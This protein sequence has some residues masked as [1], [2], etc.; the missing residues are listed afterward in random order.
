MKTWKT[1]KGTELFLLN[2][3]GKDYLPVAQR[4]VWFREERS[5]W[6]IHT[7]I[8]EHSETATLARADILDQ[9]GRIIAQAHKT[10]TAQGFADHCEKAETGAIGRALAHCGFGTQFCADELD[11]GERLADTPVAKNQTSPIHEAISE[12]PITELGKH[13]MSFGKFRGQALSQIPIEGKHGLVSYL[14]WLAG[15][16]KKSGKSPTPLQEA[17]FEAARA[18]I[19]ACEGKLAG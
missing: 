7:Q 11:E 8:V 4:I 16:Q 17:D 12:R 15:E 2:L 6:S 13:R 5:E 19:A 14:D 9:T 1:P 3:K 10:E 18:F